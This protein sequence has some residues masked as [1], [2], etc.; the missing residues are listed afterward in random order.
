MAAV[1][2]AP[3]TQTTAD[4]LGIFG[5]ILGGVEHRVRAALEALPEK[6]K[7]LAIVL[8]TLDQTGFGRTPF[9]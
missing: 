3:E 8:Q 1:T 6:R 9:F 4:I 5:P 2:G 7:K